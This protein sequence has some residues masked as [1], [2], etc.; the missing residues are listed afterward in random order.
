MQDPEILDSIEDYEELNRNGCLKSKEVLEVLEDTNPV[1]FNL[2]SKILLTYLRNVIETIIMREL[3][4]TDEVNRPELKTFSERCKYSVI[5]IDLEFIKKTAK[6][7]KFKED[8]KQKYN[9]S[10]IVVDSI[11]MMGDIRY[12][13]SLM[14]RMEQIIIR[15]SFDEIADIIVLDFDMED[16]VNN[17]FMVERYKNISFNSPF[18]KK[19][20]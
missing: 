12:G 16:Y 5:L 6:I 3:I 11:Y 2:I 18:Y 10:D 17:Y 13:N 19:L 14:K 7:R 9:R 20:P 1:E 8:K 4:V 15:K